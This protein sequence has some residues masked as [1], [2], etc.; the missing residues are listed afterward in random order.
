M[1]RQVASIFQE[2]MALLGVVVLL[3][4]PLFAQSSQDSVTAPE[5]V[6]TGQPV[7]VMAPDQLDSLVAPLALYPDPLLSQVL[8][9]STYP[10]EIVEAA[11]WLQRNSNLTGA[12][13]RNAA[14]QQNWDPSVQALTAFPDVLKQLSGNIRWTTQLGN[15]FL[16]QQ[17]A[18]M[19]AVQRLRGQAVTSGKLISTPQQVVTTE[20]QGDASAV[21]IQPADPQVIYVPFYDPMSIWGPPPFYPY[22]VLD[23]FYPY[24]FS[25]FGFYGGIAIGACFGGWRGWNGWG[26]HPNWF[27]RNIGLNSGFFNGYGYANNSGFGARA[28]LTGSSTWAHDPTHRMNVAYP[29]RQ[30]A[31]QFHSNANVRAQAVARASAVMRSQGFAA[32]STAPANAYRPSTANANRYNYNSRP[33]APRTVVPNSGYRGFSGPSRTAPQH[34]SAPSGGSFGGGGFRSGGFGGGG[35][36]RSGGHSGGGGRR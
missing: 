17:P 35:G 36:F 16:A 3:Q 11:Q 22:P 9:A 28:G 29:N 13:L 19:D 12:A 25:G 34:F 30:L 6:Q 4:V 24:G 32:S 23:T 26:W 8:V 21:E 10:L 2:F 20:T 14:R 18:V 5:P 31:T 27:G 7:P 1:K 15:E 33:V